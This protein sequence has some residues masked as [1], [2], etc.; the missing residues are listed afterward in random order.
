MR[1]PG[2]VELELALERFCD[3]VL[4]DFQRM[5]ANLT[6]AQGVE[7]LKAQKEK[8]AHSKPSDQ[9]AHATSSTAKSNPQ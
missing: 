4:S 3:E 5:P 2:L 6:F 7:R 8:L 1:D 9:A